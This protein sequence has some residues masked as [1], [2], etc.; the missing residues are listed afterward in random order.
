MRFF[1]SFCTEERGYVPSRNESDTRR[2]VL[3]LGREVRRKSASFFAMR[4]SLRRAVVIGVSLSL[5]LLPTA[6]TVSSC[7]ATAILVQLHYLTRAI[8]L[9]FID[10]SP[11]FGMPNVLV[12]S[13]A[14]ARPS[15]F[16]MRVVVTLLR[17]SLHREKRNVRLIR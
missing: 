3:F 4:A 13:Y 10:S 8:K 9:S 5:S 12:A 2:R 7:I 15:I 16:Y 17:Y 14:P 11:F 1:P 6:S